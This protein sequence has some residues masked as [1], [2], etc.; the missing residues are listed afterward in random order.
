LP[1]SITAIERLPHELREVF[2]SLIR[3]RDHSAGGN[4]GFTMTITVIPSDMSTLAGSRR[5]RNPVLPMVMG[6]VR[7]LVLYQTMRL[8]EQLGTDRILACPARRAGGVCGRLF[9]KQ[10]RKEYCSKACQAREWIR[11][12]REREKQREQERKVRRGKQT[13]QG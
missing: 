11:R 9:V 10:T 2:A 7:D 3:S 13:R 4:R 8:L 5:R 12:D 6:N 1:L